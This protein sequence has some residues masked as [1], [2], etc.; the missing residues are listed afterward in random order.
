MA[1]QRVPMTW[2]SYP[3][4][5]RRSPDSPWQV[6]PGEWLTHEQLTAWLD[7]RPK[8]PPP[9]RT[10][11]TTECANCGK[12]RTIATSGNHT[13]VIRCASI[14]DVGNLSD[15]HAHLERRVRAM[16]HRTTDPA[17][18]QHH[19]PTG[20]L[21]RWWFDRHRGRACRLCSGRTSWPIPDTDEAT[22]TRN[23][24]PHGSNA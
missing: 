3:R 5:E 12:T 1:D 18:T 19:P 2:E 13:T 8:A 4:H 15:C 11:I 21:G 7:D 9:D 20:L 10:W 6:A 24:G 14:R 17:C 23:A 16:R 22:D